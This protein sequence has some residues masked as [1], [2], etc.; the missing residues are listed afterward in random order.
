MAMMNPQTGEPLRPTS[1]VAASNAGGAGLNAGVTATLVFVLS[2]IYGGK[3]QIP[4]D[5]W[6]FLPFLAGGISFGCHFAADQI[7]RWRF[8]KSGTGTGTGTGDGD[9][10]KP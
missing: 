8:S 2:Q 1:S 6:D 3:A 4:I 9:G 5:W 10:G 7:S